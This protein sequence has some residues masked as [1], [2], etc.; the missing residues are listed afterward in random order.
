MRI[1]GYW[2]NSYSHRHQQ[3]VSHKH[4]STRPEKLLVAAVGYII[5]PFNIGAVTDPIEDRR[6]TNFA[7]ITK[8]IQLQYFSGN[9]LQ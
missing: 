6:A 4:L 2:S 1:C 9:Q 5:Q 8:L 3:L 7:S